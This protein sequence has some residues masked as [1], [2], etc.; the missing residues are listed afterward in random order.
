MKWNFLVAN[1]IASFNKTVP[2]NAENADILIIANR[3]KV[4]IKKNTKY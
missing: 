4:N 3:L 2:N 1:G